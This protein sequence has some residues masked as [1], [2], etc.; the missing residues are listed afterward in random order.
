VSNKAGLLRFAQTLRAHGV[1]IISTGGTA[2][3]L[4]KDGVPVTP[5]ERV[6]GFPEM[7]SG[8]VKTL[9]PKIHGGILGVRGD[10]QHAREMREHAIEA[11]D[12][13]CVNLYPFEQTVARPGCS[14]EEAIENIDIGGPSMVR[15]AA[16]NHAAVTVVTDPSQYARVEEELS[17]HGGATTPGLREELAAQAFALTARYDA[18]IAAYLHRAPAGVFPPLLTVTLVKGEDLRYGENPHQ[19]GALYRQL[20]GSP[21][22]PSIPH[23]EQLHGKDLSYNNIQDAAAALELVRTL[24]GLD[25]GLCGACVVKHANPCGCAVAADA[26]GAV[27][28]AIA[29]D[30]LAAYGGI[31]ALNVA[32]D[33]P[34]AE[35]MAAKE[36]FFEVIVAP[37]YTGDALA[38][39]RARWTNVRLLGVGDFDALPGHTGA[40]L[41]WRSLRGGVLAQERDDAFAQPGEIRHVA[42][43]KPT[44]PQVRAVCFLERVGRALASN[45]VVLGGE[46]SAFGSGCVRMFGGG[47]GQ[48]DRLT[49]CRIAV[50][51]AGAHAR[52]AVAYSDAFFPFADGP[53]V[54]AD[55]GV[56]CIAHPGGSKRD[57]ETFELCNRR[58]VVCLLSDRRHFR[59]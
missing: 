54:L 49:A 5:V 10:A 34:A 56:A 26:A 30:P 13:V 23:A 55:A 33:L 51:K 47:A 42:G 12:L 27:G 11:I 4:R 53:A 32:V 57:G 35:R 40:G 15:S 41:E 58:G 52:N 43:P 17:R 16:K 25:R 6:T 14:R 9:H 24:R 29:G 22:K 31:L 8:R 59:H 50:E 44:G 48:M 2:E 7:L 28:A 46:D 38:L 1:E 20:S 45:A 18:A 36:R 39:L 21:E 3:A 19:R 37:S